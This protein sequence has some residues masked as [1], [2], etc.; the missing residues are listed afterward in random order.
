ASSFSRRRDTMEGGTGND[1]LSTCGGLLICERRSESGR[2]KTDFASVF[3]F[4]ALQEEHQLELQSPYPT[5][6]YC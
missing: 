2:K 6:A 4:P 3:Y 5:A 1:N